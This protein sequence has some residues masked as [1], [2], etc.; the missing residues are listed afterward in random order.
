MYQR[1]FCWHCLLVFVCVCV[2]VRVRA[3]VR[4]CAVLTLCLLVCVDTAPLV[5]NASQTHL[6]FPCLNTMLTL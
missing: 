4:V 5:V 1:V 6:S 2:R 3:C